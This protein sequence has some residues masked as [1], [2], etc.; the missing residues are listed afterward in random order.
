MSSGVI[1]EGV[2]IIASVIIAGMITGIVISKVG[3]FEGYFTA[4]T[5]A[6]KEKMLT[7]FQI[8]YTNQINDTSVNIWVKNTGLGP[9]TKLDK[10]DAYFGLINAAGYVGYES[11]ST[12]Q[13]IF[14]GTSPSSVWTQGQTIQI[15]LNDD[16]PLII[17][18][19]YVVQ[20]TLAN[21]V[22]DDHI[23]SLG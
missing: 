20:F 21:G 19:T 12:P 2:L 8:I 17:N 18:G 15:V 9:I 4:S 5:E 3:S 6:Q 14:N 13:W 23:F 10:I 11:G 1:S 7:K 22:S 16:S